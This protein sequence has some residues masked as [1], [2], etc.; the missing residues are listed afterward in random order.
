[1]KKLLLLF[2]T[3]IFIWSCSDDPARKIKKE[4]LKKA[5]QELAE[6]NKFPVMK[7]DVTE[8]HFGKHREGEILDT[9]FHFTNTG[10]APLIISKVRTSCGCTVPEWPK[11]PIQPG[12]RGVLKVRFD[13]HHK[14]GHQVKT[15]TIHS[16][17][18]QLTHVVKI[19][20]DIEPDPNAPKPK[21][22]T[23]FKPK[24]LPKIISE[25]LKNER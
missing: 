19:I 11:E 25:E 24:H 8:I 9:V 17:E 14:K 13:T 3:A 23:N 22:N 2:L 7:F 12:E 6:M 20:A 15:I 10:E 1:M 5:K 4:N 21:K 18:K 16:N